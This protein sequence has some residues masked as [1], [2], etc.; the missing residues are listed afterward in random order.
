MRP[1]RILL[2]MAVIVNCVCCT[3]GQ[4]VAVRDTLPPAPNGKSWKMIWHD[5]FD[6]PA[7]DMTKW[8]FTPYDKRNAGHWRDNAV[9]VDGRGH[10]VIKTFKE[11]DKYID[12]CIRTRGKFEHAFGYYVASIEWHRQPG[13]YSAFWLTG[14]GVG[15]VGDEGRDG[16]EIDIVEKPWVDDRVTH[17][18]HWD[19]YGKDHKT[20]GTTVR[21]VSGVM[22]GFHTYSLLWTPDLYV[23]YVDGKETW[24]TTAGGVCQKPLW[25][26]LSD[27]VGQ[28]A[29]DI[30]KAKLPDQLQVDYVR[31]YDLVDK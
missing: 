22:Q 10:L 16:T 11:G 17:N 19:G 24:R 4:D 13:H 30:R 1:A 6:G 5:E 28:W 9:S 21:T 2:G 20:A 26:K 18:L 25:V 3:H 29:G 15:R 27:E 14:D 31:V 7:I 12:G 23:F 8:G